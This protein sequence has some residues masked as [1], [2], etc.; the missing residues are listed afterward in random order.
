MH[1]VSLNPF[2]SYA[3]INAMMVGCFTVVGVYKLLL[4][5][6]GERLYSKS[7]SSFSALGKFV[8]LLPFPPTRKS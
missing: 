7:R 5:A 2:A 8:G 6:P 1:A 3:A 4:S